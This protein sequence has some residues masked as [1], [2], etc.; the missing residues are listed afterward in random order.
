MT[1]LQGTLARRSESAR[2]KQGIQWDEVPRC[3]LSNAVSML[4]EELCVFTLSLF[5]M[6]IY[7]VQ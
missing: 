7:Q 3:G 5:C 6:G 4:K 1:Y 2:E